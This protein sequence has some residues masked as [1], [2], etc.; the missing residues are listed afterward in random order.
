MFSNYIGPY[1]AQ[2]RVGRGR[3]Q[4]GMAYSEILELALHAKLAQ[5]LFCFCE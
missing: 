1:A 3:G 4:R 5:T 2:N